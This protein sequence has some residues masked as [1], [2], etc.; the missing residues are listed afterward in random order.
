MSKPI[1]IKE[2][3][4]LKTIETISSSSWMVISF[5][6]PFFIAYGVS[7]NASFLFYLMLILTFIPFLL[8]AG[9][10][11]ITAAHL[12]TRIFSIKKLRISLLA[13]GLFLFISIISSGQVSVVYQS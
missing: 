5:I 13:I 3:L 8:I 6:P 11:G 1:K 12:L 2:I 4:R 9:G 7:Y 10:I